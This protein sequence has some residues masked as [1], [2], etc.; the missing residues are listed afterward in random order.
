MVI[1]SL[2][3]CNMKKSLFAIA[4]IA[5]ILAGCS[6]VVDNQT[7]EESSPVSPR[8]EVTLK[9]SVQD[10][11]ETKVTNDNIGAYAW[12][13]EDKITVFNTSNVGYEFSTIAGG[14]AVDFSSSSFDGTLGT[15]AMY[16]ASSN[17][18]ASL[19][20]LESSFAWVNNSSMMPMLG[21]VNADDQ[22]VSFKAVG[23]VIKLL[24][25]NVDDDAR[26]LVVTSESRKLTGSFTPSGYPAVIS[27][28]EKGDG[29]NVITITFGLGHPTNMVFYVP[30]PAGSLGR[31][32]FVMKNGSDKEISNPMTTK[33]GITASRNQ[34]IV[35]PALNCSSKT[36]IWGENFGS[37]KANDVP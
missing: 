8:T 35:A 33:S 27:S 36:L 12:Q 14:I 34:I 4:A 9:A 2:I 7:P 32:S 29:D 28:E 3:L 18:T 19:Y 11:S 26:K 1:N 10:D 20:Y 17:H 15:V 24:C 30:V 13:A 6:K 16:P 31:F 22:S 25:F 37:Y 5:V 23:G 21:A